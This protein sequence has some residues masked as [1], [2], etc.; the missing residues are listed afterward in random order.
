MN[1]KDYL[2][3]ELIRSSLSCEL[4]N[5]DIFVFD[6]IDSTNTE[7]KRRITAD[8]IKSGLFVANKQTAGRGRAGHSFYSPEN[9][10]VYISYIFTP[11]E[12]IQAATHATTKAAVCVARAI[13]DL[14]GVNPMIKWVNDIYVN[15]RKVC[16]ILSEAVTDG[17]LDSGSVVVG[18]GINI[19]TSDFP[20][21]IMSTAGAI[22][23]DN[24]V[25]RNR[26]VASIINYLYDETTNINDISY[27]KYYRQ[28]SMLTGN[29]ISYYEKEEKRY[30]T[31]IDID[32]DAGLVV[33]TTDGTV[34]TLRN[35]EV[36]TI[37]KA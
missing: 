35:G 36:F 33:R 25:S 24:T 29:D 4:N 17:R 28:H 12:G 34:T 7:A 1:N 19:E 31:V 5:L 3:E 11:A 14:Y 26:L 13:S 9:T 21:D 18:I 16:G 6:E 27:I 30:A 22:T 32:D 23:T 2:N 15:D 8:G 10:G 37:R 20:S